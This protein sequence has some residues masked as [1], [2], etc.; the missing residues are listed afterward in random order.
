MTGAAERSCWQCLMMT[1][2][3]R[4]ASRQQA[5]KGQ[6]DEDVLQAAWDLFEKE[7]KDGSGGLNQHEFFG[8]ID[9]LSK[10]DWKQARDPSTGRLYWVNPRT[11]NSRWHAPDKKEFLN[12]QGILKFEGEEHSDE[13]DNDNIGGRDE[14]VMQLN[15]WKLHL[16]FDAK[17]RRRFYQDA[18]TYMLYTALMLFVVVENMPMATSF[19]KHSDAI[20]DLVLDEEFASVGNH[21]KNWYDVMTHQELWQWV[22][23]PLHDAFYSDGGPGPQ[24]LLSTN[25]LI[26]RMQFRTAR[27]RPEV[28]PDIPWTRRC[29]VRCV[30]LGGRFD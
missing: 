18:L 29:G 15:M 19:L 4:W 25:E 20:I 7:D 17:V 1:P 6:V 23:G 11:R 13:E 9:S 3:C 26:G 21:K 2:A 12:E 14:V 27:V 8:V 16:K 28:C 22:D 30:L 24:K 5:T 10:T